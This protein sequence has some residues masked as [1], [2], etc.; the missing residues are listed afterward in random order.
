MW[1]TSATADAFVNDKVKYDALGGR[2]IEQ[3][4]WAKHIA[5]EVSASV[6]DDVDDDD[7]LAR[8]CAPCS[9]PNGPPSRGRRDYERSMKLSSMPGAGA[10][11][12]G[13][14]AGV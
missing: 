6:L 3:A 1:T 9:R 12:C 11:R 5:P 7:Y 2:R 13:S 10:S 14:Y 4:L 8:T